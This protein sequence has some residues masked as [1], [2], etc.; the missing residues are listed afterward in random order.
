[1]TKTPSELKLEVIWS[2][3]IPSGTTWVCLKSSVEPSPP[4][5][6]KKHHLVKIRL[7]FFVIRYYMRLYTRYIF[8][9]SSTFLGRFSL[10]L[11]FLPVANTVNSFPLSLTVI[12][13]GLYCCIFKTNLYSSPFFS[14]NKT[15]QSASCWALGLKSGVGW[16]VNL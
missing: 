5:S 1:M 16:T 4:E 10:I 9:T 2:K 14:F 8:R 12:F 6:E 13:S 7:L 11:Q 3:S 15:E